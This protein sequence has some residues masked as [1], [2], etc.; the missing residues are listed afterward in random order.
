M[1]GDGDFVA[2]CHVVEDI[3]AEEED[4]VQHPA[5]EGDGGWFE[6]EWWVGSRD[7]AGPG[8]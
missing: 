5:M 6:I 1:D 2:E 4:D 3:D 7:L 8:E